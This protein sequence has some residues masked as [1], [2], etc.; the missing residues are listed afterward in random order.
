MS[1]RKV[2]FPGL[3][4]KAPGLEIRIWVPILIG[5]RAAWVDRRGL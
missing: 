3:A 1:S 4:S 5:C 2:C